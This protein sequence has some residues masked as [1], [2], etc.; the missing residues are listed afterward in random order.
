M[1]KTAIF[2]MTCLAGI[3]FTSACLAEGKQAIWGT[4]GAA[5]PNPTKSTVKPMDPEKQ[6]L[7][8]TQQQLNSEPQVATPKSP[9]K[10]DPKSFDDPLWKDPKTPRI[11][12]KK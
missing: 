8:K 5:T 10:A 6:T 2:A 4:D 11:N 12:P 1:K 9:V 7:K 3:A